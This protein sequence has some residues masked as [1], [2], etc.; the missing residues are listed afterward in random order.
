MNE[1]PENITHG[2]VWFKTDPQGHPLE[3]YYWHSG[4]GRW[5]TYEEFVDV[6]D[7]SLFGRIVWKFLHR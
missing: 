4:I 5:L 3:G 6:S 2:T 1:P 7:K